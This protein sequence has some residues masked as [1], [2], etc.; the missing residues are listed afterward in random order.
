MSSAELHSNNQAAVKPWNNPTVRAII[1]QI[2]LIALIAL[3]LWYMMSNAFINME[4]R[5][6]HTGFGFLGQEAGFDIPLTL[7]PYDHTSTYGRV[8]A[9][10]IINT[11]LVS[12][13]GIISASILGFIIG[14]ARLSD[15]WMIRKI[16]AVY[17]ET[18]RNIPL[19]LQIFFWY[20]AVLRSLPSPRQSIEFADIFINIRGVF[21]PKPHFDP[22]FWITAG[23]FV[24]AIVATVVLKH[25]AKHRQDD[26]GKPFPLFWVGLGLIVGLPI[27]T[28]LLT[29]SPIQLD[30][31]E[32]KGFNFRGGMSLIPELFALWIALTIYTAAFIAETVRGGILAVPHG[33]LEAA[34]ALGLSK[35]RTLQLIIIPQAMRIIIPPLTSIFLTLTKN[36]AL[37]TAIGYP[38]LF[39]VFA[40]TAMNQIGHAVEIMGMTMLIYLML[41]VLTSAFMNWY[42]KRVALVER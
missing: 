40:G 41:S 19:L 34:S 30:Y 33:Q 8:F 1:F 29:G 7:I 18:F 3:V 11:I 9:V 39:S 25:W 15:N 21:M 22:L 36:S 20:F 2:I 17:I 42:N 37:G 10:G 26:T 31:P 12:I 35:T 4:Q 32:L 24:A 38:D 14:I 23:V 5:G 27:I 13:L 6:I 16:S 28:F